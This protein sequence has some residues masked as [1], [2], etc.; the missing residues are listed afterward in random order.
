MDKP[1]VAV[2]MG[3]I[4]DKD[5][6]SYC[7]DQLKKLNIS[8]EWKVLSAHRTP[9]A[10]ADYLADAQKRGLKAI[11]AAAG[12]AAHLA[13]SIAGKTILPVIGIPLNASDLN[14]LDALLA[15][16]QMPKGIPVATM[17]IG[18]AGA[19]NAA[20]FIGQM[21]GIFDSDLQLNLQK[22]RDQDKEKILN[23]VVE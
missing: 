10:L 15:T 5:V 14:G 17:A 18:K 3:S 9:E 13:G 22:M 12:Q 7:V 21:F 1:F 6:L 19:V 4:S 23:L 20:I 8:Y 11:I 2:L 16:V